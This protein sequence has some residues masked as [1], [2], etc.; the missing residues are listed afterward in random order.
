MSPATRVIYAQGSDILKDQDSIWGEK[1]DDGFGEALAAAPRQGRGG[2]HG[3]RPEQPAGR[4]GRIGFAV[5]VAGRQDPTS[6]CRPSRD[7]FSTRYST[8]QA[9]RA[10]LLSEARSPSPTSTTSPGRSCSPGIRGG[11]GPRGCRRS[12]GDA[13]PSGR[14]PRDLGEV[15]DQLPFHG[16][17]H[18][19][20][21]LYGTLKKSPCTPSVTACPYTEFRYDHLSLQPEKPPETTSRFP[22]MSRTAARGTQMRLRSCTSLI[23]MRR[24][25]FPC[26]SFP[27]FTVSP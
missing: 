12:F 8:R 16:L 1:A 26:G 6:P 5:S 21:Y 13:C 27:D 22:S 20:T 9:H 4:R 15:L 3:A 7:A 17:F 24:R 23:S 18:E 10:R 25:L 11:R 14:L 2:G 19:G